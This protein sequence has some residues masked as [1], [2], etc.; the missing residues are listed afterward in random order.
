MICIYPKEVAGVY[1]IK[2]VLV[3]IED[4]WVKRR[5]YEKNIYMYDIPRLC[6]F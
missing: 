2:D 5:Q 6:W 4:I 3:K 1:F